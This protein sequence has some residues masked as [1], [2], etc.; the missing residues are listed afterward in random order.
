MSSRQLSI[1][2]ACVSGVVAA[3]GFA[4]PAAAVPPPPPTTLAVQPSG[5]Q[6]GTIT[7]SGINCGT[8]CTASYPPACLEYNSKDICLAWGPATARLSASAPRGFGVVWPAACEEGRHAATC[9]IP[10][11]GTVGVRFDD[12]TGPTVEI[13]TPAVARGTI[14]LAA[15]AS[16]TETGVA[17]VSFTVG[18]TPA[19]ADDSE[20]YAASFDTRPLP[21]GTHDVSA[22][23]TNGDKI[24]DGDV[25][26]TGT[27]TR[28]VT[29]DNTPPQLSEPSGP[30][31]ET[32]GP[33]STQTWTFSAA[34]ATSGLASLE[35]SVVARDAQASYAPCSSAGAHGVSDLP[36]GS[37][38]FSVRAVDRGGSAVARSRTFLID[39]TPPNTRITLGPANGSSST[40]TS[41]AFGF[42]SNEPGSTHACRVYPA[43]LTPPVFGSCSGVDRHE[44]SGFAP[45]TYAFEVRATDRV[46]NVETP[47]KRTFTVTEPSRLVVDPAPVVPELGGG[48]VTAPP[49]LFDPKL[50]S[51][52]VSKRTATTFTVLLIHGLPKDADVAVTCRGKGCAF[53]RKRI[54]HTGGRLDLLK[55]LKRL[56]LRRGAVLEVRITEAGGRRKVGRYR[57][58]AGKPPTAT[59][60]CAPPGGALRSCR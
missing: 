2:L 21:D 1:L 43:A 54:P 16:D 45:G 18:G 24:D 20:P 17:S 44:A 41:V 59:Y 23:A 39:A 7:G 10:A 42:A 36:E 32:F 30:D 4:S 22:T 53:L 15:T 9:T 19:G 28:T 33:R 55:E 51:A 5:I 37:Y 56:R 40:A 47:A 25:A 34:D 26:D 11:V 57:I 12:L 38:T 8:V 3:G 27:A 60:L 6:L 48:G 58:R 49:A 50:V 14:D 46:G 52:Y 29:I 31:A 35:C 13:T